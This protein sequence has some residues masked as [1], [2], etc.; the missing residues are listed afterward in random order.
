[1]SGHVFDVRCSTEITVE[2]NL[3]QRLVMAPHTDV[4]IVTDASFIAPFKEA[5]KRSE[6][7]SEKNDQPSSVTDYPMTEDEVRNLLN[8]VDR[9]PTKLWVACL[10]GILERFVWYGATAPLRE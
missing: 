5:E 8:V 10:A 7:L 4:S 2:P 3:Q 6:A 1:M 9:I